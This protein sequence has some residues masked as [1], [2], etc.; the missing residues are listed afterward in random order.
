[1]LSYFLRKYINNKTKRTKKLDKAGERENET[2]AR[3]KGGKKRRLLGV[4]HWKNKIDRAPGPEKPWGLKREP[5][6][7][8]KGRFLAGGLPP[9]G[10]TNKEWGKGID[11]EE[12]EPA[13]RGN[14]RG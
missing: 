6:E 11:W 13:L 4:R 3:T 5:G 12:E 7:K 9:P 8:L 2:E 14:R 1:M 10:F